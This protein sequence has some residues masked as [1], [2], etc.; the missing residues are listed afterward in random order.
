MQDLNEQKTDK[1]LSVFLNKPAVR[2]NIFIVNDGSCFGIFSAVTLYSIIGESKYNYNICTVDEFSLNFKTEE[3]IENTEAVYFLGI[4]ADDSFL[5]SIKKKIKNVY[6]VEK[7]EED[8]SILAKVYD[9]YLPDYPRS[10]AVEALNDFYLTCVGK[11]SSK[12]TT[13]SKLELEQI[14]LGCCAICNDF[15]HVKKVIESP[16]VPE[17][18]V[19]IGCGSYNDLSFFMQE[20]KESEEPVIIYNN[21]NK[22]ILVKTDNPPNKEY[23]GFLQTKASFNSDVILYCNR[24]ENGEWSFKEDYR[25]F[26]EPSE[27]FKNLLNITKFQGQKSNACRNFLIERLTFPK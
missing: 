17:N 23:S 11:E 9:T 8:E 26:F 13:L 5:N 20:V 18:V 1:E 19:D 3:Y 25:L 4:K 2:K 10:E 24:S 22:I 21:N 7:T 16:S 12:K 14:Y 27:S 15:Q 6:V